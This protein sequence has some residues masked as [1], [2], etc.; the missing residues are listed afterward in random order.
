MKIKAE[1]LTRTLEN[2]SPT[3]Y[4]LAGD[5]PLLM[6]EAADQVRKHYQ[7]K[8]FG[9]RQIFDIDRSFNWD[10][11]SQTTGNLSLFSEQKIIELRLTSSKLEE[12]GK[13]AL[14]AYLAKPNP[15]FLIL[16]ISPKL[17]SSM[18]STKWFKIIESHSAFVQIWPINRDG[19]G[20]WLTR[21]LLREGISAE[22]KALEL[23]VDKVEGNLLAATQEIEK[24]KLLVSEE[25]KTNI[26]LD[27]NTVM[28]VVADSSRYSVYHLVDAAL[29]GDAVRS[30]KI[31]RTLRAEGLLPL[32]ILATITRELRTLLPLIE[33]KEQGQ[34]I[35]AI[36][37]TA[38]IWFNKKQAVGSAL[39]RID[40][41]DIWHFL[42]HAR[43]VDQSIKGIISANS[44]DELSLL[45][46]A[47]S[48]QSTATMKQVEV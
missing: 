36:M 14:H 1:Q 4:W 25:N 34:G 35:N 43:R 38:R 5:D 27:V 31:L 15:D 3:L 26:S 33:M 47:I 42:E 37:Q 6:Q 8:G 19:L 20:A 12:A 45:L 41:Q 9:E 22:P 18:L 24:L 23:L 16:I 11:F 30:Q 46:L 13:N 29:K 21:R 32:P 10:N 17:E 2:Q 7:N 28:Q 40:T 48:G 39:G 44:W